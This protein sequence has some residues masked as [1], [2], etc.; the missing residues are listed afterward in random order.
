MGIGKYLGFGGSAK[1]AW[2]FSSRDQDSAIDDFL[3]K[4]DP[5]PKPDAAVW[6]SLIDPTTGRLKKEYVL[7]GYAKEG[8]PYAKLLDKFRGDAYMPASEKSEYQN[9]LEAELNR[10]QE[11]QLGSAAQQ[12]AANQAQARSSLASRRGLS[13]GASERMALSG[14]KDANRM[15]QTIRGQGESQ[16]LGIQSDELARRQ[17]MLQSLTGLE[18]DVEK[19]N[20]G[21]E[22]KNIDAA[23]QEVGA[24][25]TKA[26]SDYEE[27]MKAWAAGK[28]AQGIAMAGRG[29]K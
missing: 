22:Q 1:D 25:R 5:G 24:G 23:L 11:L 4:N 7:G 17:G 29:K 19:T 12:A 16:R 27:Q 15:F 14:Q 21:T 3:K 9:A 8:S 13:T 26:Q 6:N 10:G 28:Q 18:Q 20:L 2:G